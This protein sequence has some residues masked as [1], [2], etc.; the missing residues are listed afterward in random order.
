MKPW[1]LIAAS[2]R[3][4]AG[5]SISHRAA[6]LRARTARTTAR[7]TN[8][9]T[10]AECNC[11]ANLTSIP[12]RVTCSAP[13]C[14][15]APVTTVPRNIT[16]HALANSICRSRLSVHARSSGLWIKS[17][18]R[19]ISKN[20]EETRKIDTRKCAMFD[21]GLRPVQ[22]TYAPRTT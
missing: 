18:T 22:T 9:Q 6:F 16:R 21:Q 4:I 19:L 14:G 1:A 8:I 7:K 17:S 13:E 15:P 5:P 2:R 11:V 12:N 10:D 3:K 20:A